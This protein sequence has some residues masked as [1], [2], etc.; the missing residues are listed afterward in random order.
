MTEYDVP[1]ALGSVVDEGRGSLPFALIHGEALVATAVWA[2]GESGVTPVDVGTEWVGIQDAGEPFVLH[3]PLCPMTPPGFIAEC[4]VRAVSSGAV[5]V[6]VR[7][8]TDTV[9]VL[10]GETVGETVDRAGLTVVCSPVVLPA[11]VVAE[12][13]TSPDP[14]FVT[15]VTALAARFPVERVPAPPEARRIASEDDLALLAALT[16]PVR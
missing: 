9:K 12:L 8:V 15:L 16:E 13:E 11:A 3:D 7:E 1:P 2:L 5:V 6:G 4:L 10:E 14:D